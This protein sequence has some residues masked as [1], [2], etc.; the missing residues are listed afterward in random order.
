MIKKKYPK[1]DYKYWASAETWSQNKAA[2]LLHGID[3]DSY[4][5]VQL[6]SKNVPEEFKEVQ[7]TFRI[8]RSVPWQH[9]HPQYYF[10]NVGVSPVAIIFEA[11]KKNLHMPAILKRLIR[12]RFEKEKII[13]EA[14]SD[15]EEISSSK[16]VDKPLINRER[17]NYL[18]AI[19]LLIRLLID[20]KI[21]SSKNNNL[22]LSASQI[23]RLLIE[24][25]EK[26]DIDTNGIISF[27]RKITE[28]MDLIDQDACVERL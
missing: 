4:L 16:R 1:P 28:A 26:L 23:T 3:P 27:D 6:S 5:D 13:N 7:K 15:E 18:K 9:R 14:E 22:K 20:E 25:A 21:K 2:F 17:N 8:L 11:I 12:E 10:C 24:K 19:G